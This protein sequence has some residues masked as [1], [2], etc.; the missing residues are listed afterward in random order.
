MIALRDASSGKPSGRCSSPWDSNVDR[1][2]FAPDGRR[3]M[4]C[5]RAGA[6][7]LWETAT[8]QE[9]ERVEGHVGVI[10]RVVFVPDGRQPVS[11]GNDG[12]VRLW[13]LPD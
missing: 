4:S 10:K 12:T 6:L 1:V 11:A 3:L 7:R 5:D 9:V 8:C 2:A 13:G